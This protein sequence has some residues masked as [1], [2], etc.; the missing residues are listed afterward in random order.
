MP[1]I[2]LGDFIINAAHIRSFRLYKKDKIAPEYR[3]QYPHGMLKVTFEDGTYT[4]IRVTEEDESKSL[5]EFYAQ[6]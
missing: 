3:E 1:F 6:L 4:P 2:L 5:A